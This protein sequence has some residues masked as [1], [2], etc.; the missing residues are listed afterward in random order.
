MSGLFLKPMTQ[1][2]S[3]IK[4]G[5]DSLFRKCAF[6]DVFR[7]TAAQF[8]THLVTT[9]KLSFFCICSG[10]CFAEVVTSSH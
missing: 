7:A 3:H 2:I 1:T 5:D 9:G 4:F 10:V 6:L 8:F